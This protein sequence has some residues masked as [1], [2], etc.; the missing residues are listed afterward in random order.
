MLSSVKTMDK[1]LTCHNNNFITC[2]V[3]QLVYIFIKIGVVY[4]SAC[5]WSAITSLFSTRQQYSCCVS[6]EL[7]SSCTYFH[8]FTQLALRSCIHVNSQFAKS[9]C[10]SLETICG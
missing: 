3:K 9:V 10:F 6:H 7:S 4:F 8:L 1:F 2:I 5:F